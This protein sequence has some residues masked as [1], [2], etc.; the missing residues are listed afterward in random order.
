MMGVC[1]LGYGYG[2]SMDTVWVW[3]QYGYSMY[4]FRNEIDCDTSF[5]AGLIVGC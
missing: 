5:V 1:G 3:I 2:Y 4:K